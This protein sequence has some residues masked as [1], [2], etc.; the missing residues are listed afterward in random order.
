MRQPIMRV[1]VAASDIATSK[2]SAYRRRKRWEGFSSMQEIGQLSG[3]L[4]YDS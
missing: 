3:K 1:V 2:G 4:N